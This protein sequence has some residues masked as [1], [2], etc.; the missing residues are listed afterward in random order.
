[1]SSEQFLN[2]DYCSKEIVHF[3]TIDILSKDNWWVPRC[4]DTSFSKLRTL[5]LAA[6]VSNTPS[7][8]CSKARFMEQGL[9][10][11]LGNFFRSSSSPQETRFPVPFSLRELSL[12]WL[13]PWNAVRVVS[14]WRENFY[15]LTQFSVHLL[16]SYWIDELGHF[17]AKE[18][19][20]MCARKIDKYR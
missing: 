1:M 9:P 6:R 12:R 20:R 19:T 14:L 13:S 5:R 15:N 10:S 11:P 8:V 2:S 7:A 17:T 3:Q 18:I 16:Y 4:D